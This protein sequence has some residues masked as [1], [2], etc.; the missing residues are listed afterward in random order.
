MI[1]NLI[2]VSESVSSQSICEDEWKSLVLNRETQRTMNQFECKDT[3]LAIKTLLSFEGDTRLNFAFSYYFTADLPMFKT[4][5]QIRESLTGMDRCF[6]LKSVTNQFA[7]LY[8]I[9]ALYYND[10]S[11]CSHMFL[12]DKRGK[13]ITNLR[14]VNC[15]RPSDK[16]FCKRYFKNGYFDN[17]TKEIRS[18]SISDDKHKPIE[19]LMVSDNKILKKLY[20]ETKKWFTIL[21]EKGLD[22]MRKNQ[23]PPP[24]NGLNWQ[25][26]SQKKH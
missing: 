21:Q 4:D 22:Y 12:W 3:I 10:F 8:V 26:D 15:Y 16:K 17:Q 13:K 24:T 9:S 6:S 1:L 11:F 25:L 2:L 19:F 18:I 20:K 14:S 5:E 23:I 7:A